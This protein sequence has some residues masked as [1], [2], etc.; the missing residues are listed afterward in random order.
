MLSELLG[1][2]RHVNVR[3]HRTAVDWAK[4]IK[5]L[6]D[7]MYPNVEKIILVMDNLIQAVVTIQEIPAH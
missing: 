5:Y 3:E 1:G 6:S 7:V 4:E 2:R